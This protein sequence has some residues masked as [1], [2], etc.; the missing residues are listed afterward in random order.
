MSEA[1]TQETTKLLAVI[2][3][4]D[5]EVATTGGRRVVS[6]ET[7]LPTREKKERFNQLLLLLCSLECT[8]GRH[9]WRT[10]FSGCL[11]VQLTCH[12][13]GAGCGK[14]KAGDFFV[15]I[16]LNTD[17]LPLIYH[18]R[19]QAWDC[20]GV[21]VAR[22]GG[23]L[24]LPSRVFLQEQGQPN[25][26]RLPSLQAGVSSDLT[27]YIVTKHWNSQAQVWLKPLMHRWNQVKGDEQGMPGSKANDILGD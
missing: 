18:T 1:E 19:L 24:P 12:C 9:R 7:V 16:P 22:D 15:A 2:S 6:P 14:I 21:L 11:A 3:V 26:K 27:C 8:K 10:C 20:V 13:C 4:T 5:S 17:E 23:F 25:S